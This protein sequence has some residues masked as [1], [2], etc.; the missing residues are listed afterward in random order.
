[1]RTF[2]AVLT[3][4]FLLTSAVT[5]VAE[6]AWSPEP[7][8]WGPCADY[9]DG[10]CGTLRVPLDWHRPRAATVDLAVARHRATDPAHRLGVLLVNPIHRQAPRNTA[11]LTYEGSG[12]GV[13]TRSACTRT[14]ADEY[15]L[16]LT[17]PRP[18]ASCP[19][20]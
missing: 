17:V 19:A 13:Y 15:L 6:P 1:M 16:A 11:L 10:E 12:H 5:A 4:A 18:G 20:V 8:S 3:S 9:P 14:A 7:V 2:A